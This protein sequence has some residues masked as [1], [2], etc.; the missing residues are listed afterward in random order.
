MIPF[1]FLVLV[2]NCF[3]SD[4]K[5]SFLLGK[6]LRNCKNLWLKLFAAYGK[7]ISASLTLFKYCF[8]GQNDFIKERM[9]ILYTF[10]TTGLFLCPSKTENQR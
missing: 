8:Q 3:V 10:R 6:G 7:I 9:K 1:L 5:N 2:L 4:F